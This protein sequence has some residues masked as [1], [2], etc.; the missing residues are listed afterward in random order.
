MCIRIDLLAD[1]SPGRYEIAHAKSAPPEFIESFAHYQAWIVR[2]DQLPMAVRQPLGNLIRRV[3]MG[4]TR[5]TIRAVSCCTTRS[6][7]E[8]AKDRNELQDC[9]G[10][11]QV[12]RDE[13]EV[14]LL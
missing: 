12:Y 10:I 5:Q 8:W 1:D 9:R 13:L 14:A 7:A 11:I 4:K 3:E 2:L 6:H